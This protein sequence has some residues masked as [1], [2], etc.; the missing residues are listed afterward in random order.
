MAQ[1]NDNFWH[2]AKHRFIKKNR[3]V[4][5]PLLTKLSGFFKLF[6]LKPK[7]LMLN[8][9]HNLNQEIAKIRKTDLKAKQDRKPQQRENID[10]ETIC[11]W[12]F[13]W[14]FHETKAKKKEKE[15]LRQKTRTKRKQKR[16]T[17][18]KKKGQEQERERERQRKRNRKRGR[19]KKA[20]EKQR[21]TL[22]NKQ[23]MPFSRGKTRSLCI[24]KQRRKEKSQKTKTN[25]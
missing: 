15:R 7:I 18:R 9:K 14:S 19:P 8:K 3:F 1:K 16:T 17:R 11:N 4:A 22:K 25:K 24:E 6:V 10:E 2:F 13:W 23:K 20:K 5:T 12:I 21:E